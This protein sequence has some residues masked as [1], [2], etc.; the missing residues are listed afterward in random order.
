M[1][2]GYGHS[3]SVLKVIEVVKRVAG[4]D[5]PVH[6]GP[7]RSGDPPELVADNRRIGEVLGWEPRHDDLDF[8][9]RTALDWERKM[10]D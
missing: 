4:V 3:A 7:R 8:I 9:V 10:G 6:H 1:N 2:V 5:F